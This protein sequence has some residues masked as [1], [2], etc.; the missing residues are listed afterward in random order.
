MNRDATVRRL[1]RG[2]AVAIA[3]AAV[4]DPAITSSRRAKPEIVVRAAD[5]IRDGE[6]ADRVAHR[7][8]KRFVVVRTPLAGASGT[9]IAGSRA[10]SGDVASPVFGVVPDSTEPAVEIERLVVPSVASPDARVPVVAFVRLTRAN[11]KPVEITLRAGDLVADRVTKTSAAPSEIIGVPLSFV[12]TSANAVAVHVTASLGDDAHAARADAAVDLREKKWEVLF[13]DP[14]PSWMS[15]FVRRSAERDMRFVVTSRVVTSRN[16]SS[17]AGRPPA[18]LDDLATLSRYDAIVVGAPEALSQQ[19]VAGLETFMRRRGGGVVLLLDQRAPGSYDRL[20]QVANWASNT[21]N[22]IV[23]IGSIETDSAL[24]ATELAWPSRLPAGAE[25]VTRGARPVIWRSPIGAGHL[26]VSGALDA[27][28]FRDRAAAGFDRFWQTLI[29]E[30]ANASPPPL[31][32]ET[33]S[34]IV[35]PGEA[36]EVHATV[37][38][39][40]LRSDAAAM[41]G[42]VSASMDSVGEVRLWPAGAGELRGSVRA[43]SAP[44]V[45]RIAVTA[46]GNRAEAPIVVARDVHRASPSGL[47]DSWAS[48]RGGRVVL[49]SQLDQLEAALDEAVRVEPRMETW[50]PMRSAWWIVPF[51]LA[52]SGEWWMRRRRGLK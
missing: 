46:D 28:R 22:A 24:H 50:H 5:S 33:S 44:G 49:A 14:R 38:D 48:A 36:V 52:L 37:R 34:S 32:V 16:V 39:A 12:P 7:L 9:V 25:S 15:T 35:E 18:R 45:Y 2:I 40:A 8:G 42:S 13:Y 20:T 23:P 4:V 41:R 21:G 26:V 11:G 29:A 31:S 3:V 17:D 10:P 51:V 47:V 19:D 1:L 6:L 43:P 27:W 30:T